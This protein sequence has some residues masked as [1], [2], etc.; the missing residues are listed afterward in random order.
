M[1][2]F[3]SVK[4]SFLVFWL[5]PECWLLVH[6][7]RCFL[8]LSGKQ[9][10]QLSLSYSC[11]FVCSPIRAYANLS[12]YRSSKS[13]YYECIIPAEEWF[14]RQ[15]TYPFAGAGDLFV[16]LRNWENT[17]ITGCLWVTITVTKPRYA[18]KGK[19][20]IKKF[21]SERQRLSRIP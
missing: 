13:E 5:V 11:P 12:D 17:S 19:K 9:T 4:R 15:F 10:C 18:T 6:K 2:F 14:W 8:I 7:Q 1:Y 16:C 3:P 21:W 20:K